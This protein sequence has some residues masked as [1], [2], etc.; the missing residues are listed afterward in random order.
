MRDLLDDADAHRQ[1]GY[2]RA[3]GHAKQALPRRFYNSVEMIEVDAGWVVTLDGKT[4]RTPGQKAVVVPFPGLAAAMAE[5]WAAQRELIDP[6]TMPIVRLV[7]TAVESGEE[8]EPALREE[9]IKYAGGDLL[10]YRAETPR[11]L[12]DE[13]ERQWD[14]VL[15]ALA[16]RFGVAF[17]PTIGIVHQA[18]PASTIDRLA[19]SLVPADRFELVPLVSITGLTGSGLLAIALRE[20]L[21]D[22]AHVWAAAHVDEDYNI[23][24]WGEVSEATERREKRRRDFEAAV[25]MLSLAGSDQAALAATAGTA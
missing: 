2:G 24:L 6:E 16:R 10:L 21:V 11:D 22:A 5:E 12:V 3:Q 15:V 7:N 18:Q 25:R 23:R 20:G 4:P 14:P 1:D 9:I 17:R 19:A 8:M 13:Q